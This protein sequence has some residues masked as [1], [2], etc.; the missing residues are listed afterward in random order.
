MKP[1]KEVTLAI[2]IGL[3]I[4]LIIAG[5]IYRAKTAIQNFDP[6]TLLPQKKSDVSDNPD[7]KSEVKL[8]LELGTAD[9]SV[10]DKPTFIIS[11]KTLPKTYI[12]ITTESNDYLIVPND[13]GSFSQEVNLIKGANRLTVTVFTQDGEKVEDSLSVVY[14]TVELW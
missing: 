14:T 6:Q 11:G 10:T 3:V 8:F 13:V 9:N 12:A 5:G 2:I 4:A 7:Q 1:R